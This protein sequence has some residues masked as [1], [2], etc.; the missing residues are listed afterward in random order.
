M[1][2]FRQLPWTTIVSVL[3]IFVVVL[4]L[5]TFRLGSITR[6][7]SEEERNFVSASATIKSIST[8]PINS[9]MKLPVFLLQYF[10]QDSIYSVRAIGAFYGLLTVILFYIV[11]R[12][13]YTV[14][15]ALLTSFLFVVSSWL[16]QT[17]R[18]GA[19]VILLPF[20][21][22][23]L[24]AIS[25]M[26]FVNSTSRYFLF[27]VIGAL[28]FILYIPSVVWFLVAIVLW[29]RK[30]VLSS[31]FAQPKW[32]IICA[33]FLSAVLMAPLVWAFVEN[34]QL[35][36]TW[37][38][39]PQSLVPMDMLKRLVLLPV[40][41]FARGPIAPLFNLGSLPLLDVFTTVLLILGVYWYYFRLELL[42]TQLLILLTL[43][44]IALVALSGVNYIGL[45]L[46][47]VFIVS[48]AG[49]A[50]ILQQWFTVFPKNPIARSL[51]VAVVAFTI[52][53]TGLYHMQ[54]YF[55]AWSGN[56]VTRSIFIYPHER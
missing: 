24:I 10:N 49:L 43:V 42:R 1:K 28:S 39:L 5:L 32:V 9:P 34:P 38:G 7:F 19:P 51:G 16:L 35:I 29:Q 30:K 21:A 13:W 18:L 23:L 14:R 6:G 15:V 44:S 56:P 50:I 41:L 22:I 40:F 17:A 12:Q 3:A 2:S 37:L 11:A 45:L 47:I 8:N 20:G 52:T 27:V 53:L 25:Y 36:R 48:G 46:P 55:V 54:R 4:M 31:L 33:V 26:F